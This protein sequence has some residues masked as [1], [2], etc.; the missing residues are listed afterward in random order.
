[1]EQVMAE[2]D[3]WRDK[4]R[5]GEEQSVAGGAVGVGPDGLINAAEQVAEMLFPEL[6]NYEETTEWISYIDWEAADEPTPELEKGAQSSPE[7]TD[8]N[9]KP[10][11][12]GRDVIPHIAPLAAPEPPIDA[13]NVKWDWEKPVPSGRWAISDT[14]IIY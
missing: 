1:M 3:E 10:A 5:E 9:K 8:S 6:A 7:T 12:A 14:P 11:A 4:A 13:Q 2:F